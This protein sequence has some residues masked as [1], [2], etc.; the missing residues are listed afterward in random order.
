MAR[1]HFFL[2]QKGGRMNDRSNRYTEPADGK[3]LQL[4]IDAEIQ[5]IVERELD[6]AVAT[7]ITPIVH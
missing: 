5:A 3:K 2:M 7:F 1:F 6:Q 4:T